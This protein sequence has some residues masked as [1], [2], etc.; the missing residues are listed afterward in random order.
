MQW[1]HG[2]SAKDW[3]SSLMTIAHVGIDFPLSSEGVELSCCVCAYP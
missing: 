2:N 1:I 3:E